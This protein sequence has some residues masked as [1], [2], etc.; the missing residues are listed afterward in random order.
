MTNQ[1]TRDD[2]AAMT[3]QAIDEATRAGRCDAL[4][5]VAPEA[6]EARRKT[7]AGE[8]IDLDDVAALKAVG[9]HDLI[10]KAHTAGLI[11]TTTNTKE[12]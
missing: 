10:T 12:N 11:T 5:G 9:R 3:P 2:L 6:S 1:L 8:A 7:E 4:L